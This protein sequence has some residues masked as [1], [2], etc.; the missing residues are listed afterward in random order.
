MKIDASFAVEFVNV[1]KEVNISQIFN[2]TIFS[3]KGGVIQRIEPFAK[4][5]I[6][7]YFNL[8]RYWNHARGKN[9]A[10]PEVKN[11]MQIIIIMLYH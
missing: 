2:L 4:Y 7:L 3:G 8:I 1:G 9:V 10:V 11:Y 6:R 5:N